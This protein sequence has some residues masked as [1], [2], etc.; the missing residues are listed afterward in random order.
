VFG[1]L[2]LGLTALAACL[3]GNRTEQVTGVVVAVQ[4]RSIARA[5]SIVLR[6][7]DGQELTLRVDARVDWTPGHLREHMALGAPVRV[8]YE[9]QSDGLLAV[10]VEDA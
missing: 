4:A 1:V 8:E 7:A 9:R 2:L 5:D 6:T 3:P 10:R